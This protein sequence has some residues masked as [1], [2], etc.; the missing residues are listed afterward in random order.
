MAGNYRYFY[1]YIIT[2]LL[3][4]KWY[5]GENHPM[6][7]K[8]HTEETKEKIRNRLLG[9]PSWNLGIPCR[10]VTKK[11]LSDINTER[12]KDPS[13]RKRNS[14]ISKSLWE[15]PEYRAK[16]KTAQ[17]ARYAREKQNKSKNKH[18]SN[19]ISN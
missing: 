6:Y 11:K 19:S 18:D 15:D 2:N 1:V 17:D 7:G 14:E 9:I 12:M 4:G 16:M 5:I 3:N 13:A 8:H 10:G